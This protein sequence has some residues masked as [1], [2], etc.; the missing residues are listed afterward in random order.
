MLQNIRENFQ[1][2]MAKVIIAIIIVPFALFGIESIFN[3]SGGAQAA[4]KVNGEEIAEQELQRAIA[5]QKNQLAAQ[6][7]D[8]F[9]M[10]TIKDELIRGPALDSL[11]KQALITQDAEDQKIV[12]SDKRITDVIT[13]SSY[14]QTEGKFD[15]ARYR[16]LLAG[17]GLTPTTYKT[18]LEKEYLIKQIASGLSESA[19]VTPKEVDIAAGLAQ[20]TRDFE[21]LLIDTREL[22]NK[23]AVSDDEIA[24]Y[25]EKHKAGYR[26][27]EQVNL[28]YLELDKEKMLQDIKIDEPLIKDQYKQ[29]ADNFVSKERRRVSHIL[30]EPK[31]DGS[32][33]SKID[34]IKTKID[35]G[36]D[37]AELAKTQSED[38]GSKANGGDLG[39]TEG[40]AFPKEFEQALKTL[41]LNAVTQ[42][43][44][45]SGLHL[46]KLTEFTKTEMPN[47][48]EAKS[49]IET[50]LKNVEVERIFV[51]KMEQLG[52]L[53]FNA[54]DLEAPAE[55]LK[56]K[57][58]ETGL[59]AKGAGKDI[60]ANEK[61]ATA[62]FENETLAEGNN[63]EVIEINAGHVVVVRI[64]EHKEP[65]PQELSEVKDTVV[66]TLKIQKAKELADTN[67]K[68]VMADLNSGKTVEEAATAGGYNK[69]VGNGVKRTATDA[70]RQI[71][72]KVFSMAK[73]GAAP[74]IDQQTLR[75][76]NIAVI[77]LK[78]VKE[79]RVEDMAENEKQGLKRYLAGT[80]GKTTY[81]AYE[82]WLKKSAEIKKL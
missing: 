74:I 51:E 17:S 11:I 45:E 12:I 47:F 62:A 64:K 10:S 34:A 59:F 77:V 56:L 29:E 61:V 66:Q 1:G 32:Q 21:Y 72:E 71:V 33:Q 40:D 15:P 50:D 46:V 49:R 76:A 38:V 43:K 22:Q 68:S 65:R 42:I 82:A 24:A 73:P 36:E 57:I 31:E 75:N 79:G 8:S 27:P 37:F 44:T 52:E 70:D 2:T 54:A 23:V 55:E 48:E 4:A 63:S 19:F 13:E 78:A 18:L 41:A 58:L 3:R 28:A 5:I 39:Y 69:A 16:D 53:T 67:V 6:M 26:T 14:F 9:D 20:Q 81:E 25:F 35:A 60:A 7:G 30:I 80:S